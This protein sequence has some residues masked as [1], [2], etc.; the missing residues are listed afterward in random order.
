MKKKGTERKK[1]QMG[2]FDQSFSRYHIVGVNE[3]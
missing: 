2:D 1:K 3:D